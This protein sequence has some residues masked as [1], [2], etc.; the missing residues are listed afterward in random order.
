MHATEQTSHVMSMASVPSRAEHE[1]HHERVRARNTAAPIP[2]ETVAHGSPKATAQAQQSNTQ[3]RAIER[4]VYGRACSGTHSTARLDRERSLQRA[5]RA[6]GERRERPNKVTNSGA[7]RH[8]A[9]K[10]RSTQP[11]HAT[12]QTSHDRAHVQ[13]GTRNNTQHGWHTTN[14]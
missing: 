8:A 1:T 7:V 12:E 2:S 3:R 10:S 14:E 6:R 4:R 11:M 9:N 13:G 5:E